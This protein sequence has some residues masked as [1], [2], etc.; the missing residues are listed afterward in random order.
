MWTSIL[1]YVNWCYKTC[2]TYRKQCAIALGIIVV[3]SSLIA[4]CNGLDEGNYYGRK[5]RYASK[6]KEIHLAGIF[7]INGDQGWQGG[8]V[9]FNVHKLN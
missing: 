1:S 5:H 6:K 7:P 9:G 4:C 2:A 3:L 8:Q